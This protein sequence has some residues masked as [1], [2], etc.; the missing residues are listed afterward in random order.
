LNSKKSKQQAR[1]RQQEKG[2][3]GLLIDFLFDPEDGG[4]TFLRNVEELPP[5]CIPEDG[6]LHSHSSNNFKHNNCIIYN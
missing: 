4:I 2:L 1:V 5:D 3:A 6:T